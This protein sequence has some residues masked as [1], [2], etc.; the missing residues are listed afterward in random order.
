MVLR[1]SIEDIDVNVE[2]NTNDEDREV[3]ETTKDDVI[4]AEVEIDEVDSEIE[5]I[6]NKIKNYRETINNLNEAYFIFDEYGINETSLAVF[7]KNGSLNEVLNIN[8]ISTEEY[9]ILKKEGVSISNEEVLQKLKEYTLK[10][11]EFIK[12]AFIALKEKFILKM[13]K[14]SYKTRV[15]TKYF[16]TSYEKAY[17]SIEDVNDEVIKETENN[18]LTYNDIHTIITEAKKYLQVLKYVQSASDIKKIKDHVFEKKDSCL[19]WTKETYKD[20]FKLAAAINVDVV[21]DIDRYVVDTRQDGE[22]TTYFYAPCLML[23]LT[24]ESDGLLKRIFGVRKFPNTVIT[25]NERG[26]K[27]I[28]K[29]DKYKNKG[30]SKSSIRSTYTDILSFLK[31]LDTE[32]GH[33]SYEYY[34]FEDVIEKIPK[35]ASYEDE[36]RINRINHFFEAC[37][38]NNM[39]LVMFYNDIYEYVCEE[40]LS[41]IKSINKK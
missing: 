12:K 39:T 37:S 8:L 10:G 18:C 38:E 41:V 17:S 26:K 14:L 21:V 25:L 30:W 19:N 13:Q 22:E 31:V 4:D 5:E 15:Y 32:E 29:N 9:A 3:E 20:L 33:R 7:N 23:K 27:L 6:K 11:I 28:K 24:S 40:F 36:V 16:K 2:I 34:G 35:D 1:F